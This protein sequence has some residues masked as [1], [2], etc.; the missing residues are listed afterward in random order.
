MDS[1]VFGRLQEFPY[2]YILLS[3]TFDSFVRSCNNSS[4][5]WGFSAFLFILYEY[6]S[7]YFFLFYMNTIPCISFYSI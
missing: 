4:S 7:L 3:E 6:D 5:M 2:N 1:H